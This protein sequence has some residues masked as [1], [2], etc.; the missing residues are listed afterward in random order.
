MAKFQVQWKLSTN[1]K[2]RSIVP[3]SS[4]PIA[5]VPK[6]GGVGGTKIA[7]FRQ[8]LIMRFE[9][10]IFN[11]CP[12]ILK[13][14]VGVGLIILFAILGIQNTS[15][16]AIVWLF[17]FTNW[18]G[19]MGMGSKI[20]LG[21]EGGHKTYSRLNFLPNQAFGTFNKQTLYLSRVTVL[22]DVLVKIN[23]NSA[24]FQVKLQL[25]FAK[26]DYYQLISMIYFLFVRLLIKA[27]K[28]K[29]KPHK[30]PQQMTVQNL[31]LSVT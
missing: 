2:P 12:I 20:V 18:Y 21:M 22:L 25:S 17:S 31:S 10:F 16:L 8:S 30:V 15:F 6:P 7:V 14:P 11:F 27:F 3:E 5:I 29:K 1:E 26:W 4:R 13:H 9:K 24:E 23:V 28:T 19:F